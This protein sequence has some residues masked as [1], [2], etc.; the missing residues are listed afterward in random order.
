MTDPVTTAV[1]TYET[2][3]EFAASWGFL[4]FALI[5]LAVIVYVLWP[6]RRKTF[7]DAANIPLRED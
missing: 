1:S 6:S 7:E 3:R 5:F 2:W 4:Y